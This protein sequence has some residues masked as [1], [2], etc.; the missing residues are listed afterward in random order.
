MVRRPL[1]AVA[2]IAVV[3]AL[4]PMAGALPAG[5][6]TEPAAG[7]PIV[8]GAAVAQSGGFELYDNEVLEGVQ[9]LIDEY[10]AAGGVDGRMFEL[11]V[12]DHKTERGQ[13]ESAAQKVLEEGADVVETTADYDFGAPAALADRAGRRVSM[14]ER[15]APAYGK[16]GLGPLHFNVYQGTSTRPP[17]RC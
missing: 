5:A 6:T 11:V 10:N 15:G 7:E 16:E 4:G 9:Y 12:A 13:V 14:G 8:I 1:K 2:G 17:S 3:L